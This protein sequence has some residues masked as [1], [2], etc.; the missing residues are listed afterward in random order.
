MTQ[1]AGL[2]SDSAGDAGPGLLGDSAGAMLGHPR[3]A[4]EDGHMAARAEDLAHQAPE[5]DG[6]RPGRFRRLL[7]SGLALRVLGALV[8]VIVVAVG[9]LWI[10][11]TILETQI[12]SKAAMREARTPEAFRSANTISGIIAIL[13]AS[14]VALVL[15][16]LIARRLNRLVR[17][18]VAAA[19]RIAAGDFALR[20]PAPRLGKD[21]DALVDAFNVM[22]DQLQTV[23]E[24]RKQ[25]LG[26]LAHE[27]RTP[28]AT[29]DAY[30]EAAEDGVAEFDEPTLAVLRAQTQRL[31]RLADDVRAVSRAEER[32]DLKFAPVPIEDVVRTTVVAATPLAQ[33]RGVELRQEISPGLPVVQGDRQRL[34]QVLTN[35]LDNALRHTPGGGSVT[36][37]VTRG[38][39]LVRVE[40]QDTGSGIA[41]TD[42]PHITMRFFRGSEGVEDRPHG[43]G[44]GLTIATAI[45]RAH[46]GEL[47]VHSS[48]P[49]LGTTVMFWLPT[50]GG[51][52]NG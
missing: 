10:V 5:Q 48:G 20:V 25:L 41:A 11:D 1:R 35:L 14:A 51:R 19:D 2:A 42:L 39:D 26:D 49:G 30:F 22:A 37:Y 27:L 21:V 6:S 47:R 33:E 9:T 3:S 23:E 28:I 44:V 18:V 24:K 32:V 46:H 15:S 34:E 12:F 38:T 16:L 4:R 52:P 7:T 13:V 50:E 31:A 45:V 8:L 36:V 40:V 43:S 17:G 29:L